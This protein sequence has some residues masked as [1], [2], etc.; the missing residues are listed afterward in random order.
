MEDANTPRD[1]WVDGWK[2][3]GKEGRMKYG[4]MVRMKPLAQA[5]VPFPS[6]HQLPPG[7]VGVWPTQSP[8]RAARGPS[9]LAGEVGGPRR[10]SPPQ[11]S[12]AET[13]ATY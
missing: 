12:P 10:S 3:R 8:G 9:P 5:V 13:L 4:W 6:T 2:E 11:H 1:G 7:L